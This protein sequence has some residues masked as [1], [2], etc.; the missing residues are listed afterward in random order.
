MYLGE[1]LHYNRIYFQIQI[2]K[3]EIIY[4][5]IFENLIGFRYLFLVRLR[6]QINAGNK[7]DGIFNDN[8][9]CNKYLLKF[10]CS[11]FARLNVKFNRKF[12]LKI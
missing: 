4:E 5:E 3:L 6:L 8:K 12:L 7:W 9:L 10:F 2:D 11:V 1:K